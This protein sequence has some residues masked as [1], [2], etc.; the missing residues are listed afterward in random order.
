M[1]PPKYAAVVLAAGMSTRAGTVNKLLLPFGGSTLLGCVLDAVRASG[2][3]E[4]IVVTGYQANRIRPV[5]TS[6]LHGAPKRWRIVHAPDFARGL[7]A[8]LKAG[9]RAVHP[10]ALGAVVCLGDMPLVAPA[11]VDRLIKSQLLRSL[12][13]IPTCRGKWGNPVLLSRALFPRIMRLTGDQGARPV[14]NRIKGRIRLLELADPGIQTDID[15]P[16]M[17]KRLRT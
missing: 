15:T 13:A 4:I 10:S 11:V 6:H 1:T 2:V 9:L 3:D 17:L 12:A 7:S 5:V 8:S 14:L 16:E